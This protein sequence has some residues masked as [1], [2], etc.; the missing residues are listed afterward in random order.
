MEADVRRGSGDGQHFVATGYRWLKCRCPP[1][2]CACK[3]D[4]NCNSRAI[5]AEWGAA[6][7]HG[8]LAL[9]DAAAVA[10]RQVPV[11]KLCVAMRPSQP[12]DE[13]QR[14]DATVAEGCSFPGLADLQVNK[15]SEINL[16]R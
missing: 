11:E 2:S 8:L 5:A 13:L 15:R 16:A 6:C 4:P 14:T 1:P 10:R 9:P 7:S 12:D 3:P